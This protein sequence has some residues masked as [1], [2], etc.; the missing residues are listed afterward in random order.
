[1]KRLLLLLSFS[2]C[3]LSGCVDPKAYGV[4]KWPAIPVPQD[5]EYS[6][7]E[8][9]ALASFTAENPGL[10]RKIVNQGQALRA[11]IRE[12]NKRAWEVNAKQLKSLGYE[13]QDVIRLLGAKP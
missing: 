8:Q 11:A 9:A 2:V 1:M 12:Y 4:S 13:D 10:A 5:L 7:E 6:E 3:L